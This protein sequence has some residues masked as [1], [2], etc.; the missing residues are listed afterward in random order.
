MAI[1][2]AVSPQM[3]LGQFQIPTYDLKQMGIE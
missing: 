2:N 3:N 1:K